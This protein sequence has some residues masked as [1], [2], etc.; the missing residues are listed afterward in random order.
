MLKFKSSSTSFKTRIKN[1]PISITVK[2]Y[3]NFVGVYVKRVYNQS[4]ISV[5]IVVPEINL[6][7]YFGCLKSGT[8]PIDFSYEYMMEL[9]RI[10]E[11]IPVY[12]EKGKYI[13]LD[14]STQE[15]LEAHRKE[16]T[17][18][19]FGEY[20]IPK[21]IYRKMKLF[22]RMEEDVGEI[23]VSYPEHLQPYVHNAINN[24]M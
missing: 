22:K 13:P 10:F 14:F 9:K 1:F 4:G 16:P 17:M 15:E 21:A 6:D 7:E 2:P 19:K 24:I 3:Q 23:T 18:I 5:T 11:Y 20:T 12:D 8:V